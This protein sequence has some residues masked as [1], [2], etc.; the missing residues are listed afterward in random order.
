MCNCSTVIATT[1]FDGPW[2][3]SVQVSSH[4]SGCDW[5][6]TL[7]SNDVTCGLWAAASS[8]CKTGVDA[9][10]TSPLNPHWPCLGEGDGGNTA[11][12]LLTISGQTDPSR[13]EGC[14]MTCDDTVTFSICSPDASEVFNWES[15]AGAVSADRFTPFP[16]LIFISSAWS[17][18]SNVFPV[19]HFKIPLG[20]TTASS[21]SVNTI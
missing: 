1:G 11:G 16:A 20:G 10:W 5:L 19:F 17:T 3:L 4:Q 9:A 7:V 15:S 21:A 12:K 13:R 14:G 18:L 2:V 6:F 8:L